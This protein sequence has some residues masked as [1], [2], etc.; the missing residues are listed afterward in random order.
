MGIIANSFYCLRKWD[1]LIMISA[2]IF[3][4]ISSVLYFFLNIALALCTEVSLEGL[5][6]ETIIACILVV[7]FLSE[8]C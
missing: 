2:K 6:L 4:D 5:R 8:S 1:Y 7:L 3:L